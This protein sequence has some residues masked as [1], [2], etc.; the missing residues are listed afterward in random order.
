VT[1]A[2]WLVA[3]CLKQLRYNVPPNY[4]FHYHK[5]KSV[6]KIQKNIYIHSRDSSVSVGMEYVG[7]QYAEGGSLKAVERYRAGSIHETSLCGL[8][9]GSSFRAKMHYTHSLH[10]CYYRIVILCCRRRYESLL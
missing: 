10:L 2:F 6:I 9:V 8:D 5:S 4:E 1:S 3:W 7:F